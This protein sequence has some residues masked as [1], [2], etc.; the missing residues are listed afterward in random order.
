[1]GSTQRS[2][3]YPTVKTN[4]TGSKVAVS[5]Q[6]G[7]DQITNTTPQ[8]GHG[9]NPISSQRSPAVFTS[10][11]INQRSEAGHPIISPSSSNYPRSISLQIGSGFSGAPIPSVTEK[12]SK[13]EAYGHS[14]LQ[15]KIQQTQTS[16]SHAVQMQRNVSPVREEATR[17]GG[18]NKSGRDNSNRYSLTPDAK[19]SRRLSFVDQKDNVQILQ[20]EDSPSKVQYPQ[21]VRVPRKTLVCLKDVAVETEPIR[22]S[23]TAAEIRSPRTPSSPEH[24][25]SRLCADSRLA[26]RRTP[27]QESEM[28]RHSSIYTEPKTLHRNINL[29]SALRLSV[30]KDVDGGHRVSMRTD[31]ETVRKHS[32]YSE[33]KPSPKV[34]ISS[35][36]ESNM[37]SLMRGDS[38]I[39]R[40][41]TISSGTQTVPAHPVTSRAVSESPH[42]SSMVATPEPIYKQRT[43]R[44]SESVCMSPGPTLRY[45]EPSRKPSVHA[46]LELTARPLPPRSLSR[47]GP[48]SSW[49]ALLNPEF[50]MPQ[51]RLTAPDLKP[52]SSPPLD[53]SLSFFEMDSSPFCE[54]LMFQRE[55]ASPSPPPIPATPPPPPLPSPKEPPSQAPLR[56][57][58]QSPKSTSREPTQRFNVFFLGM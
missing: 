57:V 40:R 9:S 50:E 29:E 51:S 30:L 34:L 6:K 21:G 54:D 23:V 41:V 7:D 47:Y 17:R 5:A 52:K 13:S 31:P 46:K 11:S 45:P 42:K 44:P 55:K 4:K 16:A 43:Q 26:Q 37:K 35:E 3:I 28:G 20:E 49:W 53:P 58:P 48:E 33:I 24:G 32:A 10:P 19:S 8:R 38:E 22:K 27:G 2:T 56:E 36:V 15:R 18:E 12:R 14:S 39:G 1:M 25:S